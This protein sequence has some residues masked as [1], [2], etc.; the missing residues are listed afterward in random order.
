MGVCYG[1]KD[2]IPEGKQCMGLG[3]VASRQEDNWEQIVYKVKTGADG[4]V[5]R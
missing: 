2:D 4:S 5:Q 3:E 1:N